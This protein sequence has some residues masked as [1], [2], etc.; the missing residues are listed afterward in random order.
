MKTV[1]VIQA[2][3]GST[4]LPGKVLMDICGKPMIQHVVERAQAIQGIDAVG[5]TIPFSDYPAFSGFEWFD[6]FFVGLRRPEDVLGGY[7]SLAREM[8]AD[9]IVRITGDCP[10]LCPDVSKF[11]L[12]EF[13]G[14]HGYD[15]YYNT[16]MNEGGW[17]GIDGLDTE[18]FTRDALDRAHREAIGLEREHVTSYMR[19]TMKTLYVPGFSGGECYK[20]SVDTQKD[21]DFVRRI[22]ARIPVGDYSWEA[23]KEAIRAELQQIS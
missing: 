5:I 8:G 6:P 11:V 21:L 4:R 2:R 10:L 18:V 16:A 14:A 3:L 22:M 15:L 9:V 19:R 12:D 17:I 13:W 1:C 20:L 23:T 7:Y